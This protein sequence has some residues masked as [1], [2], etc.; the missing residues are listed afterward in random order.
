MVAAN[1]T[2]SEIYED[3]PFLYRTHL[4]PKEESLE[5]LQNILAIL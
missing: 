4:T 1:R 3:K 2:V 5:K